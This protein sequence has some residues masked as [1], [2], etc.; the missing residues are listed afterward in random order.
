MNPDIQIFRGNAS[1][2]VVALPV[3]DSFVCTL[4]QMGEQSVRLNL[5]AATPV[6]LRAGDWLEWRGVRYALAEEPDYKRGDGV[7]SYTLTFYAPVHRLSYLL[8]KDEGSLSFPYAG[9]LAQ[10]LDALYT[11][12]GRE[13]S[14]FTIEI[15]EGIE[16]ADELHHLDFDRTYCLDALT[17]ICEEFGT[18][19]RIDD[20][21]I[22][23]GRFRSPAAGVFR[24][25]RDRG[26]YS[27][28]KIG[29]SNTAVVTR[30][31][32]Y[33]STENLPEGYGREK[34]AFT[35]VGG[36]SYLEKNVARYGVRE[37]VAEFDDIYPRLEGATIGAVKTP[38]DVASANGWTVTLQLPPDCN[39]IE[40]ARDRT[41][42]QIKFTSGALMGEG[43]TITAY[44]P[45]SRE[46]DF[47]VSED[48]GYR[49][50]SETRQPSV[51]DSFVLL[52]IVMP[53]SYVSRAETELKTRTQ[54]ELDRRCEKRYAYRLEIDP[55][56]VR[57]EG[58]RIGVGDTVLVQEDE[59]SA[60]VEIRVSEV[61]YPLQDP[62]R[63]SVVLSDTPVYTSYAEKLEN[64]I[65]D[66]THEVNT[67]YREA[68]TFSRRAW[69]DAEELARM[70]DALRAE[71]LLVGGLSGQFALSSAF[72][73]NRN[74]TRNS[75]SATEGKLQHAVYKGSTDGVWFLG[76]ADITLESD[77]PYYLYARCS[78]TSDRGFFY[79]TTEK[80]EVE[81]V[82]GWYY[83]PIGVISSPFEGARVFNT[84]YGFT[85]IS[86]GSVTTG[87]LRD[88]TGRL[89]IDL[90][91]GTITGPVQFNEG[92]AGLNEV[93]EWKENFTAVDGGLLLTSL[94][95]ISTDG[96]ET[97]GLSTDR[98]NV[99]LWG[100]GTYDQAK[101]NAANIVLRHDG[102][103]QLAGGKIWWNDK[104][105]LALDEGANIGNFTIKNGVLVWEDGDRKMYLGLAGVTESANDS[106]AHFSVP[107]TGNPTLAITVDGS[108]LMTH[109]GIFGFG[110]GPYVTSRD[111]IITT[112]SYVICNNTDAIT[113][114]LP[115]DP[116][117]GRTVFIRR[118][119]VGE[120]TV[121]TADGS[122]LRY[123]DSQK[124]NL[125]IGKRG[126]TLMCTY[127][128]YNTGGY[129][130]T[131]VL[132]F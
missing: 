16:G 64:D 30:L 99:L 25:G 32:G 12:L 117:V 28:E 106:V 95:K 77:A 126:Y 14:G 123:E 112:E 42:P 21:R 63:L 27:L 59:A 9:N 61:S 127:V 19:W 31:Y 8:H 98:D 78:K 80:V 17:R 26:L 92:S 102:S 103:G 35:G 104:G 44:R 37:E 67:V 108:I 81:S 128:I 124:N 66:V 101:R 5:S 90:D 87:R 97:G 115:S 49:L 58:I 4:K 56:Y 47:N 79:A 122:V 109:G 86:G 33:G 132:T 60:P 72:A 94:I 11:S 110:L 52:G 1:E 89:E 7:Y 38:S 24:Y 93:K 125:A 111:R 82:E 70:I 2:A 46:L 40:I 54:E 84:T 121:A 34:L 116:S 100:G 65:Q 3:D 29:V 22:R 71:L 113:V 45:E 53:Q 118:N 48:N 41:D 131:N 119:M 55:R 129:W 130:L 107:K 91:N 57:R 39:D 50:P 120:V 20:R 10:Q 74:N 85:Q 13:A 76:G 114:T 68:R 18:E 15:E 43:F 69:R 88:K 83:F 96:V 36:E 23:I 73:V 105:S 62:D 75:F 6:D 51:G